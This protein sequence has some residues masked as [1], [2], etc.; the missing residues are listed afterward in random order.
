MFNKENSFVKTTLYFALASLNKGVMLLSD[1][2]CGK[3][4]RAFY[5]LIYLIVFLDL[6]L[7]LLLQTV[8]IPSKFQ[9]LFLC[10][11]KIWACWMG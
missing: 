2:C 3:E 11:E 7:G 9:Q 6:W 1:I 10:D 5:C 4:S 8:M